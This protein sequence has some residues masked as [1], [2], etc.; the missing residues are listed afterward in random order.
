MTK[1]MQELLAKRDS[2]LNDLETLKAGTTE[3][4]NKLEE[5][6]GVNNAI[7]DLKKVEELKKV[8]DKE[9][10]K[11]PANKVDGFKAIV[12]VIKGR[13]ISDEAKQLIIGGDNHENYLIPE[14]VSVVINEY[15]K[16]W[17]SA[18]M[19]CRVMETDVLSGSFN[20]DVAP[21]TGLV[22]F[23]DGDTLN[24]EVAPSF[25]K[26]SWNI[27]FKGSFIPVSDLLRDNEKANLMQYLRTWFAKRAIITENT[28]IFTA[29][30]AGY[31]SGTPKA[32][33][34]W[35][36]LKASINTDL[37]PAYTQSTEM[38]IIT[39]Q[40]GFN[41]LDAALDENG[42]PI[43]QPNPANSTGKLFNGFPV[44]VFSDSQ[45]PTK[46][47]KA[48]IIYGDT[49]E[50]LW[51]ITNPAYQFA[52]DEGKGIGFTKVQTLLR[53]LEGYAIMPTGAPS[54]IYGELPLA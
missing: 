36:A 40:S 35:K 32:V 43:L 34:D 31:N 24:N 51:M 38:R 26:K 47:D 52:S 29:A 25:Q 1:E 18:K 14:D 50:A 8:V 46:N 11:K 42:R 6:E 16:E 15:K 54:Y 13:K 53:V 4:K 37:D 39:N 19:L 3:F 2:I 41:F 5:A 7:E 28:D 33:A 30:K 22:S 23:D 10:V 49:T 12:D 27:G 45:L 48:P 21:D 9:G 44:E 20:F 17:K